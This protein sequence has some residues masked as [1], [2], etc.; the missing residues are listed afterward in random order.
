MQHRFVHVAFVFDQRI[1]V[2]ELEPVFT[3]IGDD[4]VRISAFSWILWTNKPAPYIY[5]LLQPHLDATDQMLIASMNSHDF[6]GN[7]SPWIWHWFNSKVPNFAALGEVADKYRSLPP[8][9][10]DQSNY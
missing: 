3:A 5:T 6:Y 1:K 9:A 4:W 8:A 10:F 2:H 7:L